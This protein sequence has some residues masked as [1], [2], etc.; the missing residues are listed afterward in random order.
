MQAS[1]ASFRARLE[2][3]HAVRA[4]RRFGHNALNKLEDIGIGLLR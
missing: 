2:A 3:N 4:L 1:R